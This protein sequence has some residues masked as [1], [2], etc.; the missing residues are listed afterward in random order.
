MKYAHNISINVDRL[1][2]ISECYTSL[3][4]ER[5]HRVAGTSLL[6]HHFPCKNISEARGHHTSGQYTIEQI[7]WYFL[8]LSC[9]LEKP[10]QKTN[11]KAKP[12]LSSQK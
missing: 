10:M 7:P 3:C 9:P 4:L 5:N 1:E 6:K 11:V 8:M 12:K 2:T